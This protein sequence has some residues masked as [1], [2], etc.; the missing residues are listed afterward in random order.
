VD[1]LV[2]NCLVLFLFSIHKLADE[3]YGLNNFYSGSETVGNDLFRDFL[4]DPS[5]DKLNFM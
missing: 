5:Q 2:I 3:F 1:L 4:S